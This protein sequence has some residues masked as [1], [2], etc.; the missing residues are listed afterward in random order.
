MAMQF[1]QLP[2]PVVAAIQGVCFGAG[3]QIIAGADIR[4]AAPDARLS[5][6]ELAWGIIPDM[7]GYALYRNVIREDQW[8]LLTYTAQELSGEDAQQCGLVTNVAQ[9][10]LSAAQEIVQTIAMNN[11][12]AIRAAKRLFEAN[13]AT[14][15][16]E[17]LVK[18]SEEQMAI[19]RTPNQIEAF[20]SRLEKRKP[21]YR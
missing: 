1:R 6:M 21:N 3:V 15:T 9:D 5:I 10:P 19:V 12:D 14:T 13:K 8:R 2:V 11:P 7:G 4:I 17:I 16:E 20:M 18:E